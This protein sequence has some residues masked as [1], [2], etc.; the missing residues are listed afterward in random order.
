V[1]GARDSGRRPS[2]GELRIASILAYIPPAREQ[3]V[4]A[5]EP[6]G[7]GFQLERL[8]AAARGDAKARNRVAALER[9]FE[10]LVNWL[11]DLATRGLAEAMRG[12]AVER[13]AGTG[14]ERLKAA[15]VISARSAERL[16]TLRGLR[17]DLQ[18]AYAPHT[19]SALLHH[20]VPALLAELDRF[21]DR[22]ERWAK[23]IGVL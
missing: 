1:A 16:G 19:K 6:F 2:K 7:E 20:G 4:A 13:T 12:G 18:H 11:D 10:L 23:R 22:Y 17:D 14:F 5:M 3:L 9:D 15:G 8:T 21:I